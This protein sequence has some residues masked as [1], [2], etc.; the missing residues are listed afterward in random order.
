VRLAAN[1]VILWV[2]LLAGCVLGFGYSLWAM[3]IAPF[4][5]G[6]AWAV[7]TIKALHTGR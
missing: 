6:I 7:R 5:L 4:A 1:V 2:L 3:A